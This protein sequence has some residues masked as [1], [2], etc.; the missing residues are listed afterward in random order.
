MRRTTKHLFL[1]TAC[2]LVCLMHADADETDFGLKAPLKAWM[3]PPLASER[4]LPHLEQPPAVL[5]QAR[6]IDIIAAIGEDEPASF[7]LRSSTAVKALSIVPTDLTS[8][9]GGRLPASI[10]DLHVVTVWYQGGNA[11]FMGDRE[12]GPA[13]LVPEL[14]LRDPSVVTTTDS[15]KNR[16]RTEK[17]P[18]EIDENT[19]ADARPLRSVEDAKALA[20]LSLPPKELQQI[21][22]VARIPADAKPAI[23]NG[24]VKL[25]A[26]GKD[27]GSI[28]VT[29][30]VLPFRLPS[31]A[32]RFDRDR[33]FEVLLQ[34]GDI[35]P[36]PVLGDTISRA[37]VTHVISS[38]KASAGICA[39][40]GT[41]RD[42]IAWTSV[43]KDFLQNG[44]PPVPSGFPPEKVFLVR[45]PAD[46][47]P[48][49]RDD[50]EKRIVAGFHTAIA[51]DPD[52]IYAELSPVVSACL[53]DVL[54]PP[55][56]VMRWHAIGGRLISTA[57]LALSAVEN[58]EVWR[59]RIGFLP[60]QQGADGVVLPSLFDETS[61]SDS[62]ANRKGGTRA[63]A[64]V[65][66]T[67]GA[68]IPTLAWEAVREGVDDLRYMTL[69]SKLAAE[70]LS[71]TDA[72]IRTEG[73]LAGVWISRMRAGGGD[74]DGLRLEAIAWILRLRQVR[75]LANEGDDSHE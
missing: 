15:K 75:D 21:Y 2:C 43:G 36:S 56:L 41:A 37:G 29:L 35:E 42:D 28:P 19:P 54:P 1:A 23:Y 59:R 24:S 47:S 30:R 14:L 9:D 39:K 57:P 52:A 38:A 18:V 8:D 74:L 17:G 61:W 63:P 20:S 31:P 73:R 5:G 46:R 50:L 16:I 71:S 11:W 33:L 60:F 26:D 44:K 65:Y 22:L 6:G 45:D 53:C 25:T 27:A 34:A 3:V 12:P 13:V 70:C 7:V 72:K 69:L 4:I 67:T 40:I 55:H 68:P 62:D 48:A 58:P 32:T 64:L 66:P 49:A 51:A 10:L